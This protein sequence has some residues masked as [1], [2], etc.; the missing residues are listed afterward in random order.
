VRH[1]AVRGGGG[2]S[3]HVVESGNPAGR[4]VL[5]IHGWSQ[6]HASWARQLTSPALAEHLRCI[7]L[8][9]RGHGDS[10]KPPDAYADSRLWADDVRA[11]L[12]T[13]ELNGA[14]L[15]GWS[16]GGYVINDYLRHHGE[17]RLGGLH[18]V[19]AATDAGGRTGYR[20]MG[21]GWAGILPAAGSTE[22]SAYS[23]GAEEAAVVMRTFVR[24]CF[25]RPPGFPVEMTMLGISLSTPPRV[26]RELFARK[27]RNDDVLDAVTLPALVT[28]GELDAIVDV[29]TGKHIA[30]RIPGARLSLYAETGHM[31]FWEDAERFERELIEFASRLP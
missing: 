27:L 26:R 20:F 29:E 2:T 14:V 4:P 25:A 22:P 11:T 3:L 7:A 30:E 23:D 1:H 31:P 10:E 18:Y 28:H 19:S 15:C 12:E 8:D 24:R 6:S 13:L 9:L 17:A 5:F 16:Y 21:D